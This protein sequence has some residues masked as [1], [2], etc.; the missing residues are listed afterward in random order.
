MPPKAKGKAKITQKESKESYSQ[1]SAK[2]P[3]WLELIRAS[4]QGSSSS[5]KTKTPDQSSL[6]PIKKAVS[7]SQNPSQK[8]S[9]ETL[10]MLPLVSIDEIA[11]T[12]ALVLANIFSQK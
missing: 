4:D 3:S 9:T 7:Q 6:E 2:N 12:N 5:G 11:R 10:D 1:D 8:V